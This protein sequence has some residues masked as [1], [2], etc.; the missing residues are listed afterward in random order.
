MKVRLLG[1]SEADERMEISLLLV[2]TMLDVHSLRPRSWSFNSD[3]APLVMDPLPCTPDMIHPI[4]ETIKRPNHGR[5]NLVIC[6]GGNNCVLRLL[7]HL[8]DILRSLFHHDKVVGFQ[9]KTKQG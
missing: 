3:T 6:S 1:R 9:P 4:E 2:S 5:L 7:L 8:I